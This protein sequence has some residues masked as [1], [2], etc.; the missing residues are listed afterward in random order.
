M[1]F[2]SEA[3]ALA[4]VNSQG[5]DVLGLALLRRAEILLASGEVPAAAA[6]ATRAVELYGSQLRPGQSSSFLGQAYLLLGR[7]ELA[8]ARL[9]EARASLVAA[10]GHLEAT[11]G[12]DHPEARRARAA[13]AGVK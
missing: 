11:L 1:A 5:R 10:V 4:E 9:P 7:A 8:A 13:L 6:D 12:A 3:I 2:A